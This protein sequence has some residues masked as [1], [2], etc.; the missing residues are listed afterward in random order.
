MLDWVGLDVCAVLTLGVWMDG[1]C[2]AWWRWLG[3]M[4][5]YGLTVG[6]RLV[7][8]AGGCAAQM[9]PT[10]PEGMCFTG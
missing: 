8:A 7:R 1:R 4:A 3:K 10:L 9:P 5:A 6:N 2:N